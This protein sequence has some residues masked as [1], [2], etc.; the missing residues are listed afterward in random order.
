[1]HVLITG[2]NGFVGQALANHILSQGCVGES[3]V[4]RLTLLDRQFDNAVDSSSLGL[5]V[6]QHSGDLA[7]DQWLKD[8]LGRFPMDVIYHL[9]SIPGG[10]AEKNDQLGR[11]VNID[12]TMALLDL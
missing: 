3:K 6:E 7:D 5:V 1:M 11:S 8:T 4:L 2:A 9:A 10:M 12:A